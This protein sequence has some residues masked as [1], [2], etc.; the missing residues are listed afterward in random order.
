MDILLLAVLA[1]FMVYK[2]NSV[3]GTRPGDERDD[4]DARPNP[5]AANPVSPRPT[6]IDMKPVI[7]PAAAKP[8]DLDLLDPDGNKDGKIESGIAEI[9]AADPAF[10][11]AQFMAGAKYAFDMIVTSYAKGDR[12]ALKP[13]LSQKIYADFDHGIAEREVQGHT[14]VTEIHHINSAHIVEAHLGGTMAYITVDFS[15]EQTT[16]IRDTSGNIVEDSG[17]PTVVEDIWTFTRDTRSS[18]P[19]WILIE[20][21]A[22]EKPKS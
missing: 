1:I 11:A 10:D 16:T 22:A 4:E 15:I 13:L 14:S 2:L 7:K 6:I 21:R 17:R 8:L 5:F 18:D 20:T 9:V 19:N 3:L 12:S